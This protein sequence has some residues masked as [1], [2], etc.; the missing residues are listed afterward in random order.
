MRMW[1]MALP[2][3]AMGCSAP[4]AELVGAPVQAEEAAVE[5]DFS[6]FGRT[7]DKECQERGLARFLGKLPSRAVIEEAREASRSASVRVIRPGD[8]ITQDRRW[9]RL[10]LTLDAAGKIV[11]ARCF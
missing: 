2:M 5:E 6:E 1:A 9:D 10:N 11:G 4:E 8:I 3:L 7:P